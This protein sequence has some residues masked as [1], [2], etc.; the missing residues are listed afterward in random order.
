MNIFYLDEDPKKA[1]I[2]FSDQHI[3]K[4]QIESA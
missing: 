4:M 1:A 2:M 3:R